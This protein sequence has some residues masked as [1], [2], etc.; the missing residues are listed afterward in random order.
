MRREKY[1]K[2]VPAEGFDPSA[3]RLWDSRSN[4]L[5][6]T[7]VDITFKNYFLFYINYESLTFFY[8]LYENLT[9]KVK[10]KNLTLTINTKP[11]QVNETNL[12]KA[13]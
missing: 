1:F 11:I 8:L 13:R 12:K 5:S 10:N 7:G 6:Y 4:Q 9:K 3:S 2:K